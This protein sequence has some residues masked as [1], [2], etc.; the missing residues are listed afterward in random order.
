MTKQEFIRAYQWFTG[1]S[2]KE[3][4]SAFKMLSDTTIKLYIESFY[5]NAK[6]CALD[7]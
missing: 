6:R 2:K 5:D 4:E 7:D 3:A 1:C